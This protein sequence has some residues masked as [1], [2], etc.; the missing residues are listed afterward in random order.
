MRQRPVQQPVRLGRRQL[1]AVVAEDVEAR[2]EGDLRRPVAQ[3]RALKVVGVQV[4][5]ELLQA[6]G[7]VPLGEGGRG[8]QQALRQVV[9]PLQDEVHRC[10]QVTAQIW[11]RNAALAREVL[12]VNSNTPDLRL[13]SVVY[14]HLH[15]LLH[16]LAHGG[17]AVHHEQQAL[18]GGRG[19]LGPRV[20]GP[21][22]LQL[23]LRRPRLPLAP[24]RELVAA[25]ERCHSG[26]KAAGE[27]EEKA[28][29]HR[30]GSRRRGHGGAGHSGM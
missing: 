21:P 29:G 9:V 23:V 18:G 8:H 1:R 5:E 2:V 15:G 17:G 7:A 13:A 20:R 14:G 28:E 10:A 12:A 30:R 27:D 16:A 4:V 6:A 25:P 19:P 11:V 22:P 24:A 26:H 3:D